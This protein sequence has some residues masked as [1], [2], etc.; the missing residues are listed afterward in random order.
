MVSVTRATFISNVSTMTVQGA[1]SNALI[2]GIDGTIEM[3]FLD[4]DAN[5][6]VSQAVSLFGTAAYL[7]NST[8]Y[9]YG[10]IGIRARGCD[11]NL[12]GSSV[13]RISGGS[14][15]NGSNG[16][17]V[18][19]RGAIVRGETGTFGDNVTA[20]TITSDGIIFR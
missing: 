19:S 15:T 14:G 18:L 5:S 1:T 10:D 7:S 9:N 2:N 17:V 4:L 6:N 3:A 16:D 11:L 12:F 13:T 8:I 20:N